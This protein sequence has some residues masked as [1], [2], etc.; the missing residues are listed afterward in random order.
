MWVTASLADLY[1]VWLGR[2]EFEEAIA[3]GVVRLDGKPG[4]VRSFTRWFD[5]S[6]FAGASGTSRQGD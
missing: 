4:L 3:C 6:R 1:R 2:M 5:R